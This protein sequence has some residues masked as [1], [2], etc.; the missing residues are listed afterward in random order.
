MEGWM[1]SSGHRDNLLRPH[2]IYMG[3]GYVARG[4]SGSPSPTY[5]TQ[6]LSSRM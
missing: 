2:Y 1:N 4:D 5:W 6:M 3:A